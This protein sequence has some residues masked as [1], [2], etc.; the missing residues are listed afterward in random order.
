VSPGG[1]QT[2]GLGEQTETDPKI[3]ELLAQAEQALSENKLTVPSADNAYAY[4][5]AVF[6]LDPDN[7]QA[8]DGMQ[9]ILERYRQLAQQRLK[10]R[11]RRR[12]RLYASRGL[13]IWPGDPTLLAI[14]RKTVKRRVVRTRR[15]QPAK[16]PEKTPETPDFM[17][18]VE[19]WFRSGDTNRSEF[20]NQ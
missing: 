2:E 12:A 17:G 15:V 5:Q 14:K 11:D 20:L 16:T 9:R 1:E 4:Y 8:R 6:A 10:K 7:A 18:R 3:S 13:K 19:K